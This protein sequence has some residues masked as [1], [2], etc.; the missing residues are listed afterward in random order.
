MPYSTSLKIM[1]SRAFV[2]CFLVPLSLVSFGQSLFNLSEQK[3]AA[4]FPVTDPVWP[5]QPGDATVCL[6]EDDKLAACSVGVD[7]NN[8][9]D[10]E[11]WLKEAG[12]RGVPVTWFLVSGWIE[13]RMPLGGTGELWKRVKSAG[14]DVQSHSVTHLVDVGPE[15]KGIEW[16]YTESIRQIEEK[17]PGHAV[18]LLA[19]PGGPNMAKNDRQI[20]AKHF[21]SVRGVT[22]TPNPANATDYLDVNAMSTCHVGD[23]PEKP[24]CNLN[25][26]LDKNLEGGR[27]YRGWAFPFFHTVKPETAL[28]V[29]DFLAAN[30][31]RLWCGLFADVTRYGQERDTARLSTQ[32]VED[33]RIILDLVDG[34]DDRFFDY[35]LT[36]KV[37]LQ[38]GWTPASV[39]QDG[40]AI[41]FRQIEREGGVYCL[42][43]AAPDR[44]RIVIERAR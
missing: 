21:L 27:F 38:D 9:Q 44:G 5:L 34:M 6:W 39:T 29:L 20:A 36:V 31:D 37:R 35:P 10:V 24:W 42:F 17:V 15:W 8:A 33:R 43:K 26:I 14:N 41:D 12:S 7:D 19:Y 3:P 1:R 13:K 32:S 40:H 25:N 18:R 28:P 11:W 4:R 16:E 2:L 22:G 23:R 30:G